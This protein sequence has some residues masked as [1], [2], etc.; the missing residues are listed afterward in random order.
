[1]TVI[2]I[3]EDNHG[4]IGIAKN[5]KSAL[6]FLLN[7]HWIEDNTEVWSGVY[8]SPENGWKSLCQ[9]LGEDWF[10]KMCSWNIENFNDYWDGSFM[11]IETEV[12][13]G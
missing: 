10:D 9:E 13:G 6:D 4:L 11:L 2:E 7:N 3:H 1:M 8:V 5:Y 12:Y